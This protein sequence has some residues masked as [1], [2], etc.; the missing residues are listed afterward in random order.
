MIL[1]ARALETAHQTAGEAETLGT[2]DL[3]GCWTKEGRE[4]FNNPPEGRTRTNIWKL[5]GDKFPVNR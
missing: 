4:G 3:K 5:Q 1:R 2:Q